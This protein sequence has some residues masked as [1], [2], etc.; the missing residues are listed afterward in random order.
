MTFRASLMD[1]ERSPAFEVDS[2]PRPWIV[3]ASR[4]RIG[5]PWRAED[6]VA[7][8]EH[9]QAVDQLLLEWFQRYGPG[10]KSPLKRACEFPS[11]Q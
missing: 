2:L 11:G 10:E 9:L 4:E 1:G 6:H 7:L 8:L 3:E 5:Q